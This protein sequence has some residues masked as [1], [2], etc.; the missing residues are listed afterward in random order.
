[1]YITDIVKQLSESSI[2]Y[3]NLDYCRLDKVVDILTDLSKKCVKWSEDDF[4]AVALNKKGDEWDLWYC[5]ER[6]GEALHAMIDKHDA[7]VGINW[8]TIEYYL[9]MY[10]KIKSE[11]LKL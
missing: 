3:G 9:D 6:F 7:S 5:K 1:M 11:P 10:C 2:R 4:R 8:D